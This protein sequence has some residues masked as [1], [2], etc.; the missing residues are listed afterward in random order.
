MSKLLK[1]QFP[2]LKN[3][4]VCGF[5]LSP[6]RLFVTPGTVAH[7]VS[8]S[9]NFPGKNIGVGCHFLL[10]GI[11]LIQGLNPCHLH[12]Q[13]DSL[14][15][16][17]LGHSNFFRTMVID[18]MARFPGQ[19]DLLEKKMANTGLPRWLSSKESACQCRRCRFNPW[20]SKIPWKRAWQPTPVFL[21]EKSHG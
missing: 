3:G 7:Q 6:V 17:H 21:P 9:M 5:L 13:A 20:V 1:F 4:D 2:H 18:N 8:L 12:W 10:Q 11:F 15:V 14:P 19:E 16:R